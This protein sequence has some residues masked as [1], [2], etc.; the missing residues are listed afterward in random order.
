MSRLMILCGV[1]PFPVW[2]GGG[3]YSLFLSQQSFRTER[4]YLRTRS[5]ARDFV[6]S[7]HHLRM[8]SLF[9]ESTKISEIWDW[10]IVP[11]ADIR[12]VS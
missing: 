4:A 12:E 3:G 1:S 10:T 7:V 11:C 6:Q 2:P 8:I 9:V 5:L